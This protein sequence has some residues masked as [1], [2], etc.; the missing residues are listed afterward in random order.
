M[1]TIPAPNSGDAE[2][3]N[4]WPYV[5]S[6]STMGE[7]AT[8]IVTARLSASPWMRIMSQPSAPHASTALPHPMAFTAAIRLDPRSRTCAGR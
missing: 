4:G 3:M 2:S 6:S 1:S 8:T 7:N 5:A